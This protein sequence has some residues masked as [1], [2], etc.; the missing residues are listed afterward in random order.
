MPYILDKFPSYESYA[1]AELTEILS[2]EQLKS[3]THEKL[4]T[5]NSIMLI[6][7]GGGNFTI[8][9]LDKLCQSGPVKAF[10]VDDI[11]SDGRQDFIYGGNHFPTEVET[12]RY[13][14]LY[15]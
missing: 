1:N 4:S 15:P 3:S 12:A 11:N 5:M 8:K 6:N 14:A 2:D 9:N 13:D 7:D 10:Y